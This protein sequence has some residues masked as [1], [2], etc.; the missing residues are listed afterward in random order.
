MA[1]T[2]SPVHAPQWDDATTVRNAHLIDTTMPPSAENPDV[3]L[4]R[5]ARMDVLR[6]PV[7]ATV[8]TT[9]AAEPSHQ[10][11]TSKFLKVQI[12]S[13]FPVKSFVSTREMGAG[14]FAPAA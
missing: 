2:R 13:R 8:N 3:F 11:R 12:P 1:M 5:R 6:E 4:V 9:V 7:L 14:G 10:A